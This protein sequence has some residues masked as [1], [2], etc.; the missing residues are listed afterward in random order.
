MENRD[1]RGL[2]PPTER[3]RMRIQRILIVVKEHRGSGYSSADNMAR[4]MVVHV[5]KDG[6]MDCFLTVRG[7]YEVPAVVTLILAYFMDWIDSAALVEDF[8][9]DFFP[10]GIG[11]GCDLQGPE[12]YCRLAAA[13]I[14]APPPPEWGWT[15]DRPESSPGIDDA[16]LLP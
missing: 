11:A 3:E 8:C 2:T 6:R 1:E 4:P 13:G 16:E 10:Q 12:I 15:A 5:Y 7:Q 9:D 14:V